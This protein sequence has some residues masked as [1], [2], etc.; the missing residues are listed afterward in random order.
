M[1]E[2]ISHNQDLSPLLDRDYYDFPNKA[3]HKDFSQGERTQVVKRR[4]DYAFG[5][6]YFI[7]IINYIK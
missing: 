4:N 5:V 1:T 3:A 7:K 6:L 2:I